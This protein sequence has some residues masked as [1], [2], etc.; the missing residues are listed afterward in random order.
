[1][2][3][4]PQLLSTSCRGSLWRSR[5]GS[6][7]S[8]KRGM[9]I[10]TGNVEEKY[11][12]LVNRGELQYDENQYQIILDF[13][14]VQEA[15]KLPKI[16]Y[17][18]AA[19]PEVASESASFFRSVWDSFRDEKKSPALSSLEAISSSPPLEAASRRGIYLYGSV[20]IGKTLMMDMLYDTT[21]M[22]QK[23]RVHFHKV[24]KPICGGICV[25]VRVYALST[26][27]PAF[28]C[29]YFLVT[30]HSVH[31]GSP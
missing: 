6:T 12:S 9:S 16:K 8:A 11:M 4:F 21:V 17:E 18:E 1:M 22:E 19:S 25:C 28:F 15:C 7:F 10:T 30:K 27:H 5:V 2:H 14:K 20:G 31:A 29:S 24:E 3:R 23:R 13:M 26:A